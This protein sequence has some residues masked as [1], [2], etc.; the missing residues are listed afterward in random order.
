MIR[1][2]FVRE[3]IAKNRAKSPSQI[4]VNLGKPKK[5][6]G[7]KTFGNSGS[8]FF[9]EESRHKHEMEAFREEDP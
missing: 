5:R 2:P 4:K 6:C 7:P 1:S 3:K 8:G 9:G